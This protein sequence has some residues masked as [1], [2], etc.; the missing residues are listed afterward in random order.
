MPCAAAALPRPRTTLS[1]SFPMSASGAIDDNPRDEE[2]VTG[3]F[4]IYASTFLP[5]PRPPTGENRVPLDQPDTLQGGW[6][7]TDP[8]GPLF[9]I[10]LDRAEDQDKK[11]TDCWKADADGILIFVSGHIRFLFSC[12]VR[13]YRPV[14]LHCQLFNCG[15]D[16]YWSLHSGPQAK[17]PGYL[18]IL[19]CKYLSD[20]CRR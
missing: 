9:S 13:I 20:T 10:Y 3:I 7:F 1:L 6:G 17:L 8:S 15:C 14:C 11:M 16:V 18:R 2:I 5:F 12:Q 19:S 4:F